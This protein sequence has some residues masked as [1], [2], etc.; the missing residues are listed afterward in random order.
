MASQVEF[1]APQAMD[2]LLRASR[3]RRLMGAVAGG[4]VGSGLAAL[5][6]AALNLWL[7]KPTMLV[8][9][10]LALGVPLALVGALMI[11]R[12]GD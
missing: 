2:A 6:V 12:I 7:G 11:H 4:M 5:A 10:G 3:R 9:A 1:H 8:S